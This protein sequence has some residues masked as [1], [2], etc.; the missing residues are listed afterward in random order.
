MC[1]CRPGRRSGNRARPDRFR[2]GASST[3]A[4]E[5][6]ARAPNA[7]DTRFLGTIA[8]VVDAVVTQAL[9]FNFARDCARLVDGE[10]RKWT[11][12]ADAAGVRQ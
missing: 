4:T 12:A 11:V 6:A 5:C 7:G 10:L 9:A 2:T 3:L 1:E 8:S